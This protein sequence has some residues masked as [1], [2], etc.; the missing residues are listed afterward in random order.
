MPPGDQFWGDRFCQIE[1]LDGYRW[2]LA[3]K[4]AEHGAAI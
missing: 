3:H 1:D 4:S 2:G